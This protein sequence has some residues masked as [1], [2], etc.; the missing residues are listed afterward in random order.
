MKPKIST[1]I[2]KFLKGDLLSD[3]EVSC[4]LSHYEELDRLLAEHGDKYYLV[5]KDVHE[6]LLRLQ[7]YQTIREQQKRKKE[8]TL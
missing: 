6:N 5:W 7:G 3:R 8:F 1:V 2:T 4:A